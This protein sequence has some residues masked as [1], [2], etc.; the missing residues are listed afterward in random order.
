MLDFELAAH[1]KGLMIQSEYKMVNVNRTNNL[2]TVNINGFY[3]QAGFLLFG[4]NYNY[5]KVEGEFTRLTRGK[6][7]GDLEIAF[8]YDFVD[9]NDF[10]AQVYGGSAEGY[11]MGLNYHFNPNVKFMV[12]YVYTNNDRYANG[13]GKLF[14][15]NDINGN[16]TTDPAEVTQ[17]EGN[18][19]DDF[20]MVTMRMEIDF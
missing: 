20:G 8:R 4:G 5:N 17:T 13:K 2:S 11:T 10:G 19:G 3:A 9:A 1:Y 18:G 7:Y 16:L 14:V 6:E 15:G 12:N